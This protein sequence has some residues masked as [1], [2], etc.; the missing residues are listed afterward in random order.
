MTEGTRCFGEIPLMT[1]G[2]CWCTPLGASL[3]MSKC[4]QFPH[5]FHPRCWGV[6]CRGQCIIVIYDYGFFQICYFDRGVVFDSNTA[7][8]LGGGALALRNTATVIA[9]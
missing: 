7:T 2:Q 4:T 8:S 9:R 5:S 6:S 1:A 3:S